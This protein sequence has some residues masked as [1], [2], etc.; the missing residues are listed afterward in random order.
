[1]KE[2]EV[3]Q[4]KTM[5]DKRVIKGRLGGREKDDYRFAISREYIYRWADFVTIVILL[6]TNLSASPTELCESR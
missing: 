3:I 4:N 2:Q 6:L 5:Q 1:M